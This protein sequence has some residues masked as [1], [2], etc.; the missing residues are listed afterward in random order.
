MEFFL[1]AWKWL[2]L[3]CSNRRGKKKKPPR[4]VTYI[5]GVKKTTLEKVGLFH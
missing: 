5:I 3:P 4:N 1:K 2:A